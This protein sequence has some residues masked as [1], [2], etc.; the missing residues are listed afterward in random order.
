M[1]TTYWIVVTW[2]HDWGVMWH[3]E[4][5][6][7]ILVTTLLSLRALR[8]VKAKTE[9]FWFVTW[10][11]ESIVVWLCGWGFLILSYNSAKF[12]VY[13]PCENG[14]MTFFYLSRD[15][16]TLLVWFFIPSVQIPILWFQY[17][18]LQMVPVLKAHRIL[19][20]TYDIKAHMPGFLQICWE[21]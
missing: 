11:C 13:R 16:M 15:H 10:P 4:R 6:L 2:R 12:G 9:Y 8:L 3:V 5:S 21:L 20:H 1:Y 17:R 7:L 19:S 18:G 14:D